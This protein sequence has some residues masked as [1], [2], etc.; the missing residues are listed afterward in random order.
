[1]AL[2][3][4]EVMEEEQNT[5]QVQLWEDWIS[6]EYVHFLFI[7]RCIP[8]SGM[9]FCRCLKRYFTSKNGVLICGKCETSLKWFGS[10]DFVADLLAFSLSRP[11]NFR[12]HEIL[13]APLRKTPTVPQSVEHLR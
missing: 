12:L 11:C 13:M 8:G 7:F 2:K 5:K 1:M 3:M 6:M 9:R 4:P 10:F